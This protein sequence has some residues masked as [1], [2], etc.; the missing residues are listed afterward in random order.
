MTYRGGGYAIL[1]AFHEAVLRISSNPPSGIRLGYAFI[2]HGIRIT[3]FICH[4]IR[5]G[6]GGG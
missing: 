6:F 5:L 1:M 3:A 4:G 2:Y